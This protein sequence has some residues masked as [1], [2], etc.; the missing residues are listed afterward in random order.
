MQQ[1]STSL[2]AHLK[3]VGCVEVKGLNAAAV[4]LAQAKFK[5]SLMEG[6]HGWLARSHTLHRLKFW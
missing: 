6:E 4:D 2:L 5:Q 3:D 1:A